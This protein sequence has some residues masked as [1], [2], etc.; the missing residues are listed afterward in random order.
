MLGKKSS[1]KAVTA[2]LKEVKVRLYQNES[3]SDD[4]LKE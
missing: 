1:M 2:Y 4:V 3:L